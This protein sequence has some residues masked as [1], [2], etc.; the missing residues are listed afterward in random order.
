VIRKTKNQCKHE[1]TLLY[2]LPLTLTT[3]ILLFLLLTTIVGST[4][5]STTVFASNT[6]AQVPHINS[7]SSKTMFST[8]DSTSGPSVVNIT[9]GELILEGKGDP[10]GLRGLRILDAGGDKGPKIE[11]SYITN[12]TIRGGINATDMGTMWS[13][14]NPEGIIYSEGQGILISIATGEMATYTFQ[15]LGQY[16]TDGTL[17]NHGSYFFSSDTSPSREFSFLNNKIGIYE[18]KI[19]ASGNGIARIWELK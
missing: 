18:D 1:S 5:L 19:D 6:L 3:L 10:S 16:G 12:V 13:V 7:T 2:P 8:S 15:G 4:S 14:T 17:R 9:I 11:V